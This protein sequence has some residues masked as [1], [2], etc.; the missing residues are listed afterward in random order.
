MR[1]D[2]LIP[3]IVFAVLPNHDVQLLLGHRYGSSS[4]N[5]INCGST[6]ARNLTPFSQI[7]AVE[8][9]RFFRLSDDARREQKN[10]GHIGNNNRV[11][12]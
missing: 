9:A 12:N 10:N 8:E 2:N 11:K 5:H 4:Q 3:G 7:I 6:A 1:R